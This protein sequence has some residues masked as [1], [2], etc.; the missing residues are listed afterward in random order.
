M[1]DFVIEKGILQKYTGNADHV[2]I[3]EGIIEIGEKAFAENDTKSIVTPRSLRKINEYAFYFCNSLE[4]IELNEGLQVIAD[5]AF[6][7]CRELESISLPAS[8]ESISLSSFN[9]CNN[10]TRIHVDE[11]NKYFETINDVL[12]SKS[13]NGRTLLYYPPEKTDS[14][15]NIPDNVS[16][17]GESAFWGA[18]KLVSVDMLNIKMIGE[19]AFAHCK[20]LRSIVFCENLEIIKKYTFSCCESLKVVRLPDSIKKIE[21]YAFDSCKNLNMISI[22]SSIQRIDS[23]NFGDLGPKFLPHLTIRNLDGVDIYVYMPC[24]NNITENV[25]KS[26]RRCFHVQKNRI[27]FNFKLYDQLFTE[28]KNVE[29]KVLIAYFRMRNSYGASAETLKKFDSYLRKNISKLASYFLK[30]K[31][32]KGIQYVWDSNLISKESLSD[33]IDTATHSSSGK[34]VTILNEFRHKTMGISDSEQNDKEILRQSIDQLNEMLKRAVLE[35]DSSKVQ[36]L[37]TQGADPEQIPD[38]MNNAVES[39]STELVKALLIKKKLVNQINK[40]GQSPLHIAVIHQDIAII[41]ILLENKAS[42]TRLDEN[43]HSP[44]SLAAENGHIQIINLLLSSNQKITDFVAVDALEKAVLTEQI[45]VVKT[46][47]EH[48]GKFEFSALALAA[49]IYLGKKDIFTYLMSRGCSLRVDDYGD[50]RK[51]LKKYDLWFTEDVEDPYM[52]NNLM[53]SVAL[54]EQH[55]IKRFRYGRHDEIP[56]TLDVESR[57]DLVKELIHEGEISHTDVSNQFA[58]F[59]DFAIQMNNFSFADYLIE[60]GAMLPGRWVTNN[61]TN[62]IS[63]YQQYL[64]FIKHDA[65][66]ELISY[67]VKHLGTEERIKLT[68]SFL[69]DPRIQSEPERLVALLAGS[70]PD[71]CRDRNAFLLVAIKNENI[72]AMEILVDWGTLSSKNIDNMIETAQ[73]CQKALSTAYLFSCKERFDKKER[74]YKL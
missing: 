32:I 46:I 37:L 73:N 29:E 70:G 7:F 60:H 57:I 33:L 19:S 26:Y 6:S 14:H 43:K 38:I 8:L 69:N 30:V 25:Y 17:I 16:A 72:R 58:Y 13:N 44:L 5:N 15:F 36:T 3:P 42:I 4:A 66:T 49:A 71:Y 59:L 35:S 2:T 24:V 9:S 53:C 62:W 21:D 65:S 41:S 52:I 23:Y 56:T 34:F 54:S 22:P 18:K 31:D 48:I 51:Y 1:D 27:P 61:H 11:H 20:K 10:L 28:I 50:Q 40:L 74:T 39:G 55:W 68:S 45:D 67:A 64:R 12:Y 63:Q 47:Y